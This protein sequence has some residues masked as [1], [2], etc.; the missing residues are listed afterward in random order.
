MS[1]SRRRRRLQQA[2]RAQ[3]KK[4]R[5]SV[6]AIE[7]WI[8]ESEALTELVAAMLERYERRTMWETFVMSSTYSVR[9]RSM[10]WQ[11]SAPNMQNFPKR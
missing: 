6:P 8:R 2:L 7:R 4:P 5:S 3:K 1:L 11:S 10:R 9:S